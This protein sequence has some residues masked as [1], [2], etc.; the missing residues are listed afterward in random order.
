MRRACWAKAGPASAVAAA[1]GIGFAVP[2]RRAPWTAAHA[3]LD[4]VTFGAWLDR[5]GLTDTRLR[6]YLDYCCRDDYGAG[7]ATVSAWA[8]LHYF[9]SRRGFHAPGDDR[10]DDGEQNLTWPEGNAWL[11]DCE[12]HTIRMVEAKTGLL[13]LIAGNGQKG[14]GGDGWLRLLTFSADHTSL[15][16]RTFSPLKLDAGLSP[17]KD[18]PSWNFTLPLT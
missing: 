17:W 12:S 14:N 16:V 8:G 13:H 18:H 11:A 7:I 10:E 3:A 15:A 2:T 9:A 1:Q 4:A 6:W 5:Q